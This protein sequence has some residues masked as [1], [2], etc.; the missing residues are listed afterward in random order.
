M[1]NAYLIYFLKKLMSNHN[2]AMRAAVVGWS[3]RS[4]SFLTGGIPDLEL[5]GLFI[6]IDSADFEINTDRGDVRLCVGVISET[7]QET[8]LANLKQHSKQTY[9]VELI[10][11]TKYLD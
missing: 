5:H 10:E 2:D 3:D 4:K 11:K 6:Q 1:Q 9:F 8:R 7:Q